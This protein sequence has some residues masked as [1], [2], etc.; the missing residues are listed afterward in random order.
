VGTR[1]GKAKVS[2]TLIGIGGA[3]VLTF[4]NGAEI[5]IWPSHV[6]LLH[7]PQNQTQ[8]KRSGNHVLGCLLAVGSSSFALW[9]II[10]V[11]YTN[12]FSLSFST[13][14]IFQIHFLLSNL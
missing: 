6:N 7:H 4:Y 9:L 8:P 3:M 10:Q 1:V 5:E 13:F 12:H 2:G 11:G 14:P